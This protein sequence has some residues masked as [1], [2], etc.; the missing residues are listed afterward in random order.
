MQVDRYKAMIEGAGFRLVS[1]RGNPQYEFL[2]PSTREAVPT[3][4]VKSV[5]LLAVKR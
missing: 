2:S 1:I 5:S 4:G 3:Y